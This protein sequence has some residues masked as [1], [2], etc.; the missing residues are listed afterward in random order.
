MI[1]VDSSI[2][3]DHFRQA[4]GPLIALLEAE[5]VSIHPFILGELACGNFRNRKGIIAL[6][7][8]LPM[9]PKASDDEIL[10][11][12]ERHQLAGKGVGLIDMHL[13]ASC[14]LANVKL[15]TA[16]KRLDTLAKELAVGGSPS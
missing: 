4:N 5:E 8:A 10:F 14:R 13:L 9:V 16:D 12:I 1:L 7:H 3:I 6:L 15:W 2:W 11:F